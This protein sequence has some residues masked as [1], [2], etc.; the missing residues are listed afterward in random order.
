MSSTNER[1][2][3]I[4]S[5]IDDLRKR[6]R[7]L[8]PSGIGPK[9]E[10]SKDKTPKWSWP[11][12][13]NAVLMTLF[14]G[15][16]VLSSYLQWQAAL[17]AIRDTHRSFE[18]GSRAWVVPKEAHVKPTVPDTPHHGIVTDGEG[19]KD[20]RSPAVSVAL[21]NAGHSPALHLVSVFRID[22]RP[23]LPDDDDRGNITP[24]PDKSNSGVVLAPESNIVLAHGQL[25]T[26]EQYQNIKSGKTYF[27]IYG[28]VTYDDIFNTRHETRHCSYYQWDIE[29]MSACPHYN[30]AN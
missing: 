14:T 13:L 6:F 8:E 24:L 21:V 20:S 9:D 16:L 18:I 12:G 4:Q 22:I 5:Q 28:I 7:H 17:A 27:V 11:K 25:F 10:E 23:T 30:S 15:L 29:K 3:H 1:F 19:L 2:Q 26:E